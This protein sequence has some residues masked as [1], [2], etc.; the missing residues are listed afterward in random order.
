MLSYPDFR[1]AERSFQLMAQVSGRSGRKYK[2]GTVI[3]QTYNPAHTVLKHVV[4]NNYMALF[5]QQM[6]ERHKY[7]YPPFTRLILVK[8]KHKDPEHLNKASVQLAGSLRTQFGKRVLG[9]EFPV[10]AR[11]MNYYI[12]HIMIKIERGVST[13]AMKAKLMTEVDLF[14]K[15]AYRQVRIVIDVDPQ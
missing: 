14:R 3:I 15:G 5:K 1:S 9:P 11:I 4:E 7:S 2:Q 13:S 6:T 10:V 12:K 8:L